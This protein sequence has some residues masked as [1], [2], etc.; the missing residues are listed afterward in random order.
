MLKKYLAFGMAMLVAVPWVSAE[1][2]VGKDQHYVAGDGS[3]HVV[4][5]IQNN[6]EYTVSQVSVEAVLYSGVGEEIAVTDANSLVRTISPGMKAPFDIVFTG[7]ESEKVASYSLDLDYKVSAPKSQVI[8]IVDSELKRDALNN[9]MITGT[10]ANK[11]EITANTVSVV[12]TLYDRDGNVA[13]VSRHQTEPDYLRSDGVAHFVVPVPDKTQ[14]ES[15]VDYVLVAES[16]E[17]AAV[18]EFPIGSGLLLAGSVGAYI[19]ITRI[20]NRFIASL[21]SAAD[22]R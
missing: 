18:P 2:F 21:V 11:G 12:A 22:P 14:S 8:E 3:L 9:L 17:Y 10:V 20:P 6:L 15:V 1:V 13:V 16:E 5:E 4:G 19:A 7:S